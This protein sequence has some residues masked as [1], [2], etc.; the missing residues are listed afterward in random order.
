MTCSLALGEV[1]DEAMKGGKGRR[2]M[3]EGDPRWVSSHSFLVVAKGEARRLRCDYRSWE[4]A[5]TPL[6]TY[7]YF[8]LYPWPLIPGFH[9]PKWHMKMDFLWR[10]LLMQVFNFH[11]VRL[12]RCSRDFAGTGFAISNDM[13]VVKWAF[14]PN[15][16]ERKG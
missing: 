16:I 14:G 5:G 1:D 4:L 13:V 15:Q 3:C 8:L 2:F 12:S 9:L 10:R 11:R 6:A 7:R